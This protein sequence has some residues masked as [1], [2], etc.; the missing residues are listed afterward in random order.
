MTISIIYAYVLLNTS[1][2]Y[3]QQDSFKSHRDYVR[4][5]TD[6][7]FAPRTLTLT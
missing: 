2:T 3:Q 1:T 6:T 7:L 4:Q 5:D